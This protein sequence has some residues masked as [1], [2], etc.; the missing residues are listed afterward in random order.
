MRSR[1]RAT[2]AMFAMLAMLAAMA[3]LLIALSPRPARAAGIPASGTPGDWQQFGYDPRHS[4][5][6][7]LETTLRPGNV[8]TLHLLYSVSLPGTVDD[9]PVFLSGVTTAAGVRDV[10]Y[11]TTT[12]GQLVAVDAATGGVLWSRQPATG[13]QYTTSAP[14][15]DPSRQLVYSYGLEGRVHRYRVGDGSEVTG[16]GWPQLATLKPEVEKCSPALAVATAANRRSY[17]YVAN[18]GYPGDAGDYQG[19]VTAV[20]LGSGAQ[21]VWNA[22]CSD[23]PVHF[24]HGNPD[25]PSVQTAV[26][27]RGGVVY[28]SDLDRILF[29]TGN[30]PFDVPQGG[31]DWGDSVL[32]LRPSG[33]GNGAAANGPLDSYTPVNFQQ[34]QN[35]DADLGS[36]APAVLPAV[37]GS[38]FPH[39]A[40][41]GGK[42][43]N[44]RLLNLDNLSGQGQPGKVGGELQSIP[45]P[46]GGEV[47]TAVAVWTDPAS[48]TPW[49]FVAN[50]SGLSGIQVAAG[51]DGTPALTPMWTDSNGGTSPVVADAIVF[52]VGGAGLRALSARHGALLW[53]D[54]GPSSIHWQSPI[55]VDGRVYVADGNGKL[56]A[57]APAAA[58]SCVADATTLCLLGGRFQV[59]AAWQT[60]DGATGDGQ[61]AALTAD[62]GYFWFFSAANIEV[63]T[64]ALNGCALGNHFWLFAGGLT[65]VRVVITVTDTASG[66]VRVYQNAQGTAFAPLQDTR[67]FACGG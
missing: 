53:S 12:D 61:A 30:G 25:C 49:I 42:D 39:L 47:L 40:V 23:Q 60:A 22:N 4:G 64:K 17:L 59:R 36:T 5:T 46:Q 55:V 43:G 15:V 67:A 14:A 33:A 37:P 66:A 31:H 1:T 51:G 32:E 58:S 3:P 52:Y 21:H 38:R 57:Y 6:A 28:D 56:W 65:N 11:V 18:G 27:Q 63:V 7:A 9:A 29:A 8:G 26:W 20:D 13:P 44:L 50:D 48:G 54:G 24:T 34:L 2:L 62:T 35:Q 16:G 45:V 19:H 41:Q 10:L